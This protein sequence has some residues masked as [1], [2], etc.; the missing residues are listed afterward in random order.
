MGEG[1]KIASSYSI[2]SLLMLVSYKDGLKKKNRP[3]FQSFSNA[4]L[5]AAAVSSQ[6]C[7]GVGMG[8]LQGWHKEHLQSM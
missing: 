7:N 1:E 2:L 6:A 4:D 5:P 8:L 3:R